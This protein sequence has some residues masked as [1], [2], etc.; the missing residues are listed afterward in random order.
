M[1]RRK[2]PTSR[3]SARPL[4]RMVRPHGLFVIEEGHGQKTLIAQLTEAGDDSICVPRFWLCLSKG[5][6]RYLK[7]LLSIAHLPVREDNERDPIFLVSKNGLDVWGFHNGRLRPNA[8][9]SAT[10]AGAGDER[11]TR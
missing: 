6:I 1:T 11:K 10:G 9:S 8:T 2:R 3:G 4:Q 5:A 7:R